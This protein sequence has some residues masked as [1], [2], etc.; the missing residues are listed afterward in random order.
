LVGCLV[1]YYLGRKGGD[2][3]VRRRFGAGTVDHALGV[4]QRNGVLAVL[5]PALLPPPA[6]FKIFVILAGVAGI[7]PGRFTTAIL[8][9]RGIRYFGEG[10]LALW[11]GERAIEFLR[12]N[13][14]TVGLVLSAV[15]VAG[16]AAYWFRRRMRAVPGR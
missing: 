14:G 1:L 15:L 7:S 5:I 13:S 4:V 8:L 16:V 12:D 9:G 10:L 6:P 11:Y 2:A 3:F